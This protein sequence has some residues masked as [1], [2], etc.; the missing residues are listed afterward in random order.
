VSLPSS[1]LCDSGT[2]NTNFFL[3]PFYFFI[4]MWLK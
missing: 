1:I 2:E 3:T 4:H